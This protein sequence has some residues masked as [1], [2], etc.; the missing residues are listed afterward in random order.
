MSMI[1]DALKRAKESQQ[2]QTPAGAP[3]LPPVET[4]SRGGMGWLVVV[5]LLIA[6]AGFLIYLSVG[7][8]KSPAQNTSVASAA[9]A[10][11]VVVPPP[12]PIAP[13]TN[14]VTAPP[15]PAPPVLKL[16]GIFVNSGNPQAIVNG[17]TVFVGDIVA[18]F[19]VKI[20]SKDN[21]SLIAPDG[22]QKT[23]GLGE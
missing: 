18:G 19:R 5:I 16:Q 10:A 12:K 17:Q 3:P 15:K 8:R 7:I 6:V 11:P 1:N 4:Q 20:I 22:T 23:L 14:I 21:V 9:P 2:P 13:Q